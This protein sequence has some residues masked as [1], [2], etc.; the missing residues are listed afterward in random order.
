MM[1][2]LLIHHI[3]DVQGVVHHVNICA[4]RI[5][6]THPTTRPTTLPITPSTTGCMIN[7]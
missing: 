5:I 7:T 2:A 4:L 6:T 3:P 1:A